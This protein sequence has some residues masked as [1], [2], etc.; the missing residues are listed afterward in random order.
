MTHPPASALRRFLQSEAAGGIIL[1][2]AAALA[3]IVANS[4]MG[5]DYFAALAAKAGPLSVLHWV[6]DALMAVFFF[7]VGL[8]IKREWTDGIWRAGVTGCCRGL[9]RWPGWSFPRSSI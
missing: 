4:P 8:E 5:A 9:P 1:M 7:L 3:L 6:N 2:A